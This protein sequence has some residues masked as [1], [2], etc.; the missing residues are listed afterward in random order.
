VLNCVGRGYEVDGRINDLIAAA[1]GLV[2]YFVDLICNHPKAPVVAPWFLLS[3]HNEQLF[4][5]MRIGRHS[6]RRTQIDSRRVPESETMGRYNQLLEVENTL[7]ADCGI[8]VFSTACNTRRKTLFRSEW[9][10]HPEKAIVVDFGGS[11]M[12]SS[13]IQ[14]SK[15]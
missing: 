1:N 4:A 8:S 7:D 13:L 10:K 2:L 9:S 3:D 12:M 11:V 14:T 5:R 6:G 15:A